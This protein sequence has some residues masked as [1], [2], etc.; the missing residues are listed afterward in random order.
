MAWSVEYTEVFEEWWSGLG[1]AEQID[2][3]AVIGLLEI[4]GP[5]LG[6][7]YS[8]G[9][10]GS[11]HSHM[12]ELR[13]QHKGGRIGCSMPSIAGGRRSCSWAATRRERPGGTRSIFR[14]PISCTMNTLLH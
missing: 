9:I 4:K 7:P 14:L 10:E 8:S 13:I 3:D 2:I 1:E 11:R 6:F 5:Q 12:R